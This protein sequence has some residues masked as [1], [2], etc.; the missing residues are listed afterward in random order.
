VADRKSAGLFGNI[1]RYLAEYHN[2]RDGKKFAQWLYD[3][4]AGYD[5]SDNQM[6]CDA[7]LNDLGVKRTIGDTDE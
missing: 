2:D 5:F 3:Q 4:S 1:F 7:A 6:E